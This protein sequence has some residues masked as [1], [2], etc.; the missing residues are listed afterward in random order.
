MEG[1]RTGAHHPIS[2]MNLTF[3]RTLYT[4]KTHFGEKGH[5]R[6]PKL[7]LRTINLSVIPTQ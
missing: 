7:L 2:T 3:N 1:T 5:Q 6:G 4:L